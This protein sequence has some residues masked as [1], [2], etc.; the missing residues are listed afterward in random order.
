VVT[1]LQETTDRHQIM[2]QTKSSQLW[3]TVDGFRIEQALSNL[4]SNAIKYSPGGG[5]IEVT[6]EEDAQ[7]NEARFRIRDQ[8]MGIPHAQQA[9]LFGRFVRGENVREAGIRGTGLGLY[10]CRELVERHGGSISFASEEGVG[11]TFFFSLSCDEPLH[12]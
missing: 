10:L 4:L 9:Q 6:L 11:S 2:F 12:V 7:T 5:A 8:G 3:A 1:Q